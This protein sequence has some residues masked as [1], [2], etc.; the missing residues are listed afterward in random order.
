MKLTERL[1]RLWRGLRDDEWQA[2]SA[3]RSLGQLLSTAP[4]L[5][6]RLLDLLPAIIAELKRIERAMPGRRPDGSGRGA[7]RL[8]EFTTWLEQEHQD[9]LK[10]VASWAEVLVAGRALASL[11]VSI[12]NAVGMFRR[13]A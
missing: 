3:L 5:A 10:A 11:L 13:G 8:R 12:L 1:S 9:G 4:E 6:S 7:D 2:L